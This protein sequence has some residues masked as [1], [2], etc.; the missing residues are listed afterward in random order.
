MGRRVKNGR[1]KKVC[2]EKRRKG[3]RIM[4]KKEKG[5][6]ERKKIKGRLIN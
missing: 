5:K 4:E 2:K 6:K 3:G 1:M